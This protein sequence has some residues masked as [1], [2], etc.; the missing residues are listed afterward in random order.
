VGEQ[1]EG[2]SLRSLLGQNKKRNKR[3]RDLGTWENSKTWEKIFLRV[4]KCPCMESHVGR[5]CGFVLRGE[6]E[7]GSLMDI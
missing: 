1:R 5:V 4:P 2:I 3:K 7:R 6:V